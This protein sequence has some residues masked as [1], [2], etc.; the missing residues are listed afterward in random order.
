MPA[1]FFS[2]FTKYA[3]HK[4]G[5]QYLVHH[6]LLSIPHSKPIYVLIIY[7]R[8]NYYSTV[9]KE[10]MKMQDNEILKTYMFFF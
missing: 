9:Q 2:L 7:F 4:K 1:L 10:T 6:F 5:I 3:F 8:N